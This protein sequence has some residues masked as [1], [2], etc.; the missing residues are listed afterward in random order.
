LT[1]DRFRSPEWRWPLAE[2]ILDKLGSLVLVSV[3]CCT[4]LGSAKFIVTEFYMPFPIAS[5]GYP[6]LAMIS[7]YR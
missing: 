3:A 6:L 5:V 7:A 1:W 4:V 2:E